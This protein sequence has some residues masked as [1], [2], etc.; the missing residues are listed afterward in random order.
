MLF[1][2]IRKTIKNNKITV[3]TLKSDLIDINI[4]SGSTE[5]IKCEGSE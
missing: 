5:S 2:I 4:V 1:L 3:F